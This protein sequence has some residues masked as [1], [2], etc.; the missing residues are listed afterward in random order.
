M[1][2]IM[3]NVKI[4][5]NLAYA[6][7]DEEIAELNNRLLDNVMKK[8]TIEANSEI[9]EFMN[10]VPFPKGLIDSL[11]RIG[12]YTREELEEKNRRLYAERGWEKYI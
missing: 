8:N 1:E 6:M 11:V 2:D 7:T 10:T 9:I 5:D 4:L 12:H 3:N